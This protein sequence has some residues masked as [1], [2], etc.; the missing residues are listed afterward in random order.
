MNTHPTSGHRITALLRGV[1]SAAALVAV[2]GAIP[3]LLVR[4]V[5]N[6]WPGRQAFTLRDYDTLLIGVLAT[7]G[8]I[9]L[10]LL[11]VH[12]IC[13]FTRQ[14]SSQRAHAREIAAHRGAMSTRTSGPTLPPPA[15]APRPTRGIVPRLVAAIIS[16]LL[17][18]RGG[19][20]VA[21]AM[22]AASTDRTPIEAT[23]RASVD[24]DQPAAA[25][26]DTRTAPAPVTTVTGDSR[27]T[28]IVQPRDT[29]WG[30]AQAALG[31]SDRWREIWDLNHDRPQSDGTRLTD[32]S[33]IHVG[34]EL[35]LPT[36]DT[37][38]VAGS[39]ATGA[40][41][42]PA[43]LPT[44]TDAGAAY[45]V[46]PGDGPWDIA[47]ALVGDGAEW[48]EVLAAN[49]G[50]EVTP[51]VVYTSDT[52]HIHPGWIFAQPGAA[53]VS[54]E[55]AEASAPPES[56]PDEPSPTEA[57][58][59][60]ATQAE[61]P[62]EP[63]RPDVGT[64]TTDHPV[65]VDAADTSTLPVATT[66]AEPVD[67]ETR[68][69]PSTSVAADDVHVDDWLGPIAERI[70]WTGSAALAAGLLAAA[71]QLRRA[72]Y[73]RR[74]APGLEPEAETD[75]A[76]RTTPL[77]DTTAWAAATLAELAHT[78][79]P[80]PDEPWPEP[81]IVRL[82]DTGIEVL[83]TSPR[84]EL[85]DGWASPDGGRTWHRSRTVDPQPVDIAPPF[86]ALVTIARHDGADVLVNLET[87]GV[88]H[89]V[90]DAEAVRSAA[91]ALSYEAAASP[92]REAAL[93]FIGTVPLPGASHLEWAHE[94]SDITQATHWLRDRS[95]TTATL[96]GLRRVPSLAAIRAVGVGDDNHEPV[97]VIADATT[98][99]RAQLADLEHHATPGSGAAIVMV[100]TSPA[101]VARDS[102]AE[103]WTLECTGQ[104]CV[105]HPLG[106]RMEAIGLDT[107]MC[108]RV[109]SLLAEADTQAA[110]DSPVSDVPEAA[111][112]VDN[113]K[114][115]AAQRRL[116]DVLAAGVVLRILGAVRVDGLP[117]DI[118]WATAELEILAYLALNR[119]G[120]TRDTIWP[121]G[122]AAQTWRNAASRLRGKLG[123]TPAGEP[124]LSTQ[125]PY[126]RYALSTDVVTDFEQ[127]NAY[128]ELAGLS[129]PDDAVE[130]YTQAFDLLNGP[131]F[132]DVQRGFSWAYSD[133]TVTQI[134]RRVRAAAHAALYAVPTSSNL[135]DAIAQRC[136]AAGEDLADDASSTAHIGA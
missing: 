121:N 127:F 36:A 111:T 116:N 66:A 132:T 126:G 135:H 118:K 12:T 15:P 47:E 79:R 37:A 95:G 14:L 128:A 94:I 74:T 130:L 72:R 84:P 119:N 1:A 100:D 17:L 122:S 16:A 39:P 73:R 18:L 109:G 87:I 99:D 11:V 3:V 34:W 53:P 124:R 22:P 96:T 60:P 90:G 55:E 115:D 21:Q 8:W 97:I 45:V 52:R 28:W 78:L 69:D 58:E 41:M 30:I 44:E 61:A 101:P 6:P 19:I 92:F 88:L 46:Q 67:Q 64:A 134:L 54:P 24:G 42:A 70:G 106:L 25:L 114:R 113:D 71:T 98:L 23:A 59:P 93:T 48:P 120:A 35:L 49:V 29:L 26:S 5:G 81:Q 76:L 56:S 136:A 9:A 91:R 86:P 13:E 82:D 107:A 110:A 123:L 38:P 51:G 83:W 20:G 103:S 125:G 89:L 43:P 33:M 27:P 129:A 2:F 63:T 4:T 7:I 65:G 133:G 32:P 102:L 105:L 131:C 50:H 80:A 104:V 10:V 40:P 108:E 68:L 112:T 85:I 31:D 117:A 57:P 75:L 62:T 77:L